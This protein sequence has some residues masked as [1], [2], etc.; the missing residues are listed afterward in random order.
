MPDSEEDKLV[1]VVLRL[2]DP[3]PVMLANNTAL[4]RESK[5]ENSLLGVRFLPHQ[6]CLTDGPFGLP[7]KQLV[8]SRIPPF[9]PPWKCLLPT[10]PPTHLCV[11]LHI[12]DDLEL[13]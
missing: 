1:D 11:I 5:H 8:S 12:T 7:T 9:L 3:F 2:G 4:E 6:G 13:A 10:L